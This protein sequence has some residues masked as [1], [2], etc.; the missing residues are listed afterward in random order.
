MFQ[1]VPTSVALGP[2]G[3]YYVGQL[4]G[5]PFVTGA[6]NVYRLDPMTGERT[7]AHSGFTNII[8]LTFGADGS[9]YVLQISRDGL[10]SPTGPLPGALIRIEPATGMRTTIASEG[11]NFPG[12]VVTGP[13]GAIYVTNFGTTAGAGQVLRIVI[14]EPSAMVLLGIGTLGLVG[15]RVRTRAW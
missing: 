5:V 4:T 11:L 13:D 9:L 1:S 10:A 12:G 2:D 3:A 15:L 7:I 8:D 6:A 14:P